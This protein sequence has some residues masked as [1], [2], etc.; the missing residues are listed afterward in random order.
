MTVVEFKA[1]MSDLSPFCHCK[2]QMEKQLQVV[3]CFFC[4][5]FYRLVKA[6]AKRW[7]SVGLSD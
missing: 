4:L 2:R 7:L 5:C 3:F 6:K 1:F